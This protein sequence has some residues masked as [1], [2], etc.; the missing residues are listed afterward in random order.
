MGGINSGRTGGWPTAEAT[1]SFVLTMKG[2]F[3]DLR[4]NCIG[5]GTL[6]FRR[7][8]YGELPVA[9]RVDTLDR[10][11]PYVELTHETRDGTAERITYRV[12]LAATRPHYG[13][14]RWWFICPS[15]VRRTFKLYLPLGGR[16]FLSRGAYRLG[17]AVTREDKLSRRQR[18]AYRILAKLGQPDANWT[19]WAAKPKWMRWHTYERLLAELKAVQ[20]S[21][22]AIFVAEAMRR[23]GCRF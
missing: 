19:A 13:G 11:A 9:V 10:T 14:L 3:K 23:F 8:R 18:R 4:W 6:T 15:T 5:S 16:R 1:G 7:R 12:A 20:E 22:E 2:L 21:G 17:Y